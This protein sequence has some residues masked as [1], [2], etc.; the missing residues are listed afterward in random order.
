MNLLIPMSDQARISLDQINTIWN[1]Q[2]M[3]IKKNSNVWIISWFNTKFLEQT[4][5]EL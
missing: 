5:K 4:S 2:V 3:R 1:R